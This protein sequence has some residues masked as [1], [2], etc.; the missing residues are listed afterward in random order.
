MPQSV[1]PERCPVIYDGDCGFCTLAVRQMEKLDW[2]G[3]FEPI[4]SQ[5][6][7]A[8]RPELAKLLPQEDLLKAIHG[9]TRQGQVVSGAACMRWICW[10]FPVGWP[11]AAILWVLA[12]LRVDESLYQWVADNRHR[13]SGWLGIPATCGLPKSKTTEEA[14]GK[15]GRT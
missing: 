1:K 12:L 6:L 4:S 2:F 10:R 11:V 9:V 3:C 7:P 8:V 5:E 13:I 14:S 15:A